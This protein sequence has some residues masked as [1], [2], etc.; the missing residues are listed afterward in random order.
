MYICNCIIILGL[1]VK[2][3]QH[4]KTVY[5]RFLKTLFSL[6]KPFEETKKSVLI[7]NDLKINFNVWSVNI[8]HYS[9][10]Y[11]TSKDTEGLLVKEFKRINT[12]PGFS[13]SPN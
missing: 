2:I 4:D 11:S 9:L 7:T 5:I 12:I 10:V 8:T 6:K 1:H 13:I 3:P